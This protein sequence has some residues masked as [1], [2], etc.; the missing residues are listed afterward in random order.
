[1][2]TSIRFKSILPEN[3]VL[4]SYVQRIFFISSSHQESQSHYTSFP[5]DNVSL[6]VVKGRQV[7]ETNQQHLYVEKPYITSYLV[8][9]DMKP[10][11]FQVKGSLDEIC[12]EFTTVGCWQFLPFLVRQR[13]FTDCVVSEAFGKEALYFFEKVFDENDPS[14]RAKYVEDFLIRKL[15]QNDLHFVDHVVQS[16]HSFGF[17]KVADIA[18]YFGCTEKRV[19]RAFMAHYDITPKEYLKLLRFRKS[20]L[21]IKNHQS[22]SF[23]DVSYHCN[24]Y[25][26]SH[27]NREFKQFT[28]TTP[29]SIYRQIQ[30]V[31]GQ[32]LLTIS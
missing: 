11:S 30:D 15:K 16:V 25:D 1:M 23:L 6:C 18:V 22:Q 27:F 2:S 9:L 4:R 8:G 20:L 29:Q 17:T 19:Y 24:Y 12:I 28:N 13:I 21:V 31:D 3:L 5:N 7:V 14:I 32:V 10:N 26:Q